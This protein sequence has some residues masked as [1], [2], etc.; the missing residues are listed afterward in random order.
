MPLFHTAPYQ[1]GPRRGIQRVSLRLLLTF[2]V[3]AMVTKAAT[4][5]YYPTYK[6]D[7]SVGAMEQFTTSLTTQPTQL[8]NET[9]RSPAAGI[10]FREHP[11]PW[12]GFEMNYQYSRFSANYAPAT[13]QPSSSSTTLQEASAGYLLHARFGAVQPF[14]AVGGGELLLK[15]QN[16]STS[17]YQPAAL[18][19][20]GIDIPL[21]NP[22]F[23]FTL[24]AHMLYYK[25]P[26][27]QGSTQQGDKWMATT[28]PAANFFIRF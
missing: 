18:L 5:Q 4:A 12:V 22:H 17:Y 9:A 15:F 1:A 27:V 14:V 6:T 28:E 3:A 11:N 24:H 7:I 10:S 19:D 8:Y 13:T 23:G 16:D 25:P 20:A 2:A 26:T 21:P